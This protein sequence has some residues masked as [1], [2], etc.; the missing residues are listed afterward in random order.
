MKIGSTPSGLSNAKVVT[1]KLVN[2]DPFIEVQAV[3]ATQA[4]SVSTARADKVKQLI[5]GRL[6]NISFQQK[7]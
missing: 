6:R 4:N 2:S 7:L 3:A 1:M 5:E